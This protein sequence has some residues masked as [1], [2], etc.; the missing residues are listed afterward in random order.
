M[1]RLLVVSVSAVASGALAACAVGPDFVRPAAPQTT[2]F[3]AQPLPGS[4]VVADGKAQRFAEGQ[5]VAADWWRLLSCPQLDAIVVES[6]ARNPGLEA[7][8]ATLRMS[9]DTLRAGYGV[10]VPQASI[11]AGVTRESY[12]PAPGIIQA[13]ST[14][15]TLFTVSANV[16]YAIDIWG[17]E[18]RQ[19]EA[20]RAQVDDERYALAGTYIMLSGNVVNTVIAQAGYRAE[21]DATLASI[22]L[23]KEQLRI[24]QA[25]AQ[26]GTVPY[27]SVL[28][29]Q[30]QI[31]ST[32]A[33]LPPLEQKVDQA[34][35]LLA[36]LAGQ[37]P[38]EWRQPRIA[39]ADL[40]L[41]RDLPVSLP[42]ELVR[43]RPDVLQAEAVLHAANANI[44]MAT[45][46]MLPNL[47]LSAGYGVGATSTGSGPLW[48][49]GAGLT[50]P[51]FQEGT[52]AYQRKAAVDAHDASLAGYRQTVLSAFEQV[53]DTLRGLQHDA[54]AVRAQTEAVDTA[55]AAMRLIQANYEAGISNYLQVL[56]ADGQYLL[57]RIGYVQAVTLR[58]QDTVALYVALGG[59]WW[60]A[61]VEHAVVPRSH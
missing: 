11:G 53:A 25:Q 26:G 30:S 17:G 29:I 50:Q 1:R 13:P 55:G 24:T 45:A 39:L 20:L 47:T 23:Q 19:I 32:E 38:A 35:N 60:D 28:S 9:Q 5:K 18:R 27:S 15:F 52:L 33:T 54:E 56:V 3:T 7:A 44:G 40:S 36:A 58:L 43:Q 21:I 48:N 59:G 4:T 6:L 37:T 16:S 34:A 2:K 8:R 46:A 61:P 14:P 12:N 42:S 49:L 51:V 31:A 10:F 57:A 41:P 22:A